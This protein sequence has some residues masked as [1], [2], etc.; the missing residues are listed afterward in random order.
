M[1]RRCLEALTAASQHAAVAATA[2]A[3]DLPDSSTAACQ[4]SFSDDSLIPA[5][6]CLY[7]VAALLEG[8]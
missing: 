8:N 6:A 3:F 4:I 7:T 2:G 1:L 5:A